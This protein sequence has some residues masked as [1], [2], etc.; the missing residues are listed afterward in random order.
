MRE[1]HPDEVLQR[2]ARRLV[3]KQFWTVGVN[4]IWSMDQHNKCR[5]FQLF[6]HVGLEA[7]TSNVLWLK[8]WWTNRNPRLICGWYCDTVEQIGY[9]E[10]LFS[11]ISGFDLGTVVLMLSFYVQACLC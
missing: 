8:V 7:H 2:K 11:V 10:Y 6:L 3:R 5:R 9:R 4:D 1:Y